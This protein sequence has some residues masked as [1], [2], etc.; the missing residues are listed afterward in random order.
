[1]VRSLRSSGS[2]RQWIVAFSTQGECI[3][4]G[5]VLQKA[6]RSRIRVQSPGERRRQENVLVLRVL[7]QQGMGQEPGWI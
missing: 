4:N 2:Q 6:A 3:W 1:M 5:T 7:V